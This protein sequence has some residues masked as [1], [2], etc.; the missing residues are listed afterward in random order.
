MLLGIDGNGFKT[1]T[2]RLGADVI[3]FSRCVGQ[4]GKRSAGLFSQSNFV[5]SVCFSFVVIECYFI[6]LSSTC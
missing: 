4:D 2:M 6:G 5:F 3:V 1:S